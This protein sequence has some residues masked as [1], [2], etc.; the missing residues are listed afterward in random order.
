M[1]VPKINVSTSCSI[2]TVVYNPLQST[3]CLDLELHPYIPAAT[4]MKSCLQFAGTGERFDS[5]GPPSS[6]KRGL[7]RRCEV[8]R[9]LRRRSIYKPVPKAAVVLCAINVFNYS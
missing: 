9:E 8:D 4:D 7:N 6:S 3:I 5:L 1:N 2:P